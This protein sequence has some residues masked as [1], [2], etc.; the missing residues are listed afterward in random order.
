MIIKI[1]NKT[2]KSKS[3]L[4]N[5]V[6]YVVN[7]QEVGVPLD[8]EWFDVVDGVLR[9]H[10]GYKQKAGSGEYVIYTQQCTVN[11]RN[12][13]FMVRREDG[14]TT[15]FSFYK[16]LSPD[17][18]AS[19]VKAA[20]RYAVQDQCI[21]YKDNYF[22]KNA[23]ARGH[24]LCHETGLKVTKKASHLDHYPTQFDEIVSNWFKLNK[25]KLSD[26]VLE[27]SWDNKRQNELADTKLVE[28]FR[29]Y[30]KEVA[31]YRIVLAAVN[32][33]RKK[34]KVSKIADM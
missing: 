4:I 26:I 10:S 16:A 30:H 27:D 33:Q 17:N 12:R 15:D 18:K 23:S 31:K 2:F 5:Y 8:G 1:A 34:A 24:V 22:L 11:P 32:L 21:E 6:K 9:L 25:L 28:S 7:N 14:S 13:N 29:N 3:S 20:L 19:D